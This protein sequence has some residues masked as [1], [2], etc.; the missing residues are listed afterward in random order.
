M[1]DTIEARRAADVGEGGGEG[2]LS[3]VGLITSYNLIWQRDGEC[4]NVAASLC[5]ESRVDGRVSVSISLMGR[6]DS[7]RETVRRD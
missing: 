6:E 2:S 4:G 1:I 5:S 3:S 7:G